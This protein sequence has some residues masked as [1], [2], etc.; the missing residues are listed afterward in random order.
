M[1]L[2]R[3]DIYPMVYCGGS[4]G[5]IA[6]FNAGDRLEWQD[7][8][9]IF[10]GMSL[11]LSGGRT[12]LHKVRQAQADLRSLMHTRKEA[13]DGLELGLKNA[14][15]QLETSRGR[16][17]STQA[18]IALAQKGYEI[19]KRAYE[20]G[21][22]TLLDLHKSELDLKTARLAF[23]AAQFDVHSTVVDIRTLIGVW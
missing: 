18:L 15:E 13:L 8:R 21:S 11:S 7:D 20:V 5:K 19:S 23:Q 9:K 16:W 10:V 17:R 1:K 14:Y 6:Q 12:H 2:A 22:I 3:T 4:L